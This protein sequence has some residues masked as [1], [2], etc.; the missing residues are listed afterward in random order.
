MMIISIVISIGLVILL[1]SIEVVE[2]HLM[3]VV[4]G[5]ILYEM[6]RDLITFIRNTYFNNRDDDNKPSS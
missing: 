2:H 3:M 1:M 4:I 5:L 6:C